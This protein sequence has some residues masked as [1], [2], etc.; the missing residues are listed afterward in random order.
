VF[1]LLDEATRAVLSSVRVAPEEWRIEAIRPR[2]CLPRRSRRGSLLLPLLRRCPCPRSARRSCRPATGWRK[3][4][5]LP[6]TADRRFF[7][8]GSHYRDRVPAAAI[9][10]EVDAATAFGTGEHPSTR[11][12]LIALESLARRHRFRCPVRHRHGHRDPLRLP[13]RNCCVARFLASDIDRGAVRVARPQRR[14]QR[15]HGAG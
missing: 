8:Y 9:G 14:P 15:R 11:A 4:A 2:R 3:P 10:I 5:R 12:C 6:A 7:V 13:R 1:A